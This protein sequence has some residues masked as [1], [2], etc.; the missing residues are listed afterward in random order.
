MSISDLDSLARQTDH[1]LDVALFRIVRVP[2]NHDVA[3]LQVSP[4]N[5]LNSVINKL[6]HQKPLAVVQLRQH[7][8]TL[9]HHRLDKENADQ[10]KDDDDQKNITK[11]P[12]TF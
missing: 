11:K 8:R 5:A 3:S 4:A 6:I 2:K 1:T 7:R 10:Y 12:Q 9:D